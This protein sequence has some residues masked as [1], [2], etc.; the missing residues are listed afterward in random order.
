MADSLDDFFAKKDK[1]RAK[2]KGKTV[3]S[4]ESLVRELEEGSKQLDPVRKEN[5]TSTA[6]ELL[7]LDADDADWR[8]FDDVEKR[9][10]TGLKVKEMSL[11]DQNDDEQR[12]LSS[13]QTELAPDSTAWKIKEET[14]AAIETIS[15]AKA[16]SKVSIP[17]TSDAEQVSS[18]T[19]KTDDKDTKESSDSTEK[20]GDTKSA[21]KYVPRP[22]RDLDTKLLEPIRLSKTKTS[23]LRAGLKINIQDEQDFPSLG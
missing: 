13:D 14:P 18:S 19:E 3:F 22:A 9:D 5:K 20:K 23:T 8:D 12:R 4:A 10:Y 17:T 7:G 11:Q 21:K 16:D 6:I 1:K 15:N 2:D